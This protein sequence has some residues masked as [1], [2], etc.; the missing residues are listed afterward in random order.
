MKPKIH[1]LRLD[2]TFEE[3]F[4]LIALYTDEE[5]YRLAYLLNYYIQTHFV[6]SKPI[7]QPK[8]LTEFSVFEYEDTL[9]YRTLHL[10]HNY[11]LKKLQKSEEKDLFSDVET[12]LEKPI[13]CFKEFSK[14]RFLLKVE[15]EEPKEYYVTLLQNI[16]SIPQIYAAEFIELEQVKNIDLLL[17]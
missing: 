10:I 13:Y 14:A 6:K 12:F 4:R 17:F 16:T 11:Y 15:A 1:K 5:D 7:I 8:T 2:E 9:H 3:D